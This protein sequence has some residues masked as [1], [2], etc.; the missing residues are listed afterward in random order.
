MTTSTTTSTTET[1][2]DLTPPAD[3]ARA[4]IRT[5]WRPA[6]GWLCVACCALNWLAVPA[7]RIGAVLLGHPSAAHTGLAGADLDQMLPVLG[8]LLGIGGMRT[9]EKLAGK[10]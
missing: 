8:T 2:T 7:I 10:G 5:R 4:W 6:L 1:T 3:E 9:A